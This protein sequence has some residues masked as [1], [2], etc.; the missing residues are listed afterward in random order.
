[1]YEKTR[2]PMNLRGYALVMTMFCDIICCSVHKYL[3]KR[4][5]Q[6]YKGVREKISVN[7][8]TLRCLLHNA[9]LLRYHKIE[10]EWNIP[11][12]KV[13]TLKSCS[14]RATGAFK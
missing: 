4:N 8:Q 5:I 12:L 3:Q 1:M 13:V 7:R 6:F 10:H 14:L 11:G 9:K 2:Y